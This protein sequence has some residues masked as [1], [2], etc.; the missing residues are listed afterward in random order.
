MFGSQGP[1]RGS[2]VTLLVIFA[3]LVA[4]LVPASEVQG[5]RPTTGSTAVE[6]PEHP[7]G[8]SFNPNKIKDIKAAD[9]GAAGTLIDAPGASNSGDARLS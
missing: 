1:L 2:G 5:A 3:L 7:E 6:A 8:E 4:G 9:P